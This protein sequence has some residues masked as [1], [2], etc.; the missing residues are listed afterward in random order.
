[1]VERIRAGGKGGCH[2]TAMR[3]ASRRITQ[4]YDQALAPTGMKIT[5]RAILAQIR[6]SQPATMGALAEELVM[7]PGGLAH[8]LKPLVRDGLVRINTDPQDRRNRSIRLTAAGKAALKQSDALWEIANLSFERQF[9]GGQAKALREA[10][11]LLISDAFVENFK[12]AVAR[13]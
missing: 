13:G 11:G 12:A 8:T 1:M 4:L 7:D 6:R 9:T 3:K 10:I 2:C 5:Q